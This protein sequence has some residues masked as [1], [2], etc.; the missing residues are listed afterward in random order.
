[1]SF[2][3]NQRLTKAANLGF[4]VPG[5]VFVQREN[6]VMASGAV[7]RDGAVAYLPTIN[8]IRSKTVQSRHST[9]LEKSLPYDD[10]RSRLNIYMFTLIFNCDFDLG[11]DLD[12]VKSLMR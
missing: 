6:A 7:Y 5:G 12:R 2:R 4:P 1:M 10:V 9:M 8:S 11:I 3:G